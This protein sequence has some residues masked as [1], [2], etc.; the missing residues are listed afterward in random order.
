MKA[1][2]IDEL[3]GMTEVQWEALPVF[4]KVS[5]WIESAKQ[6]PEPNKPVLGFVNDPDYKFQPI[7]RVMWMPKHFEEASFEADF[8]D[9]DEATDC[10]Y[11]PEGWYETNFYEETHWQ[12]DG[13]VLFWRPLPKPPVI[14]SV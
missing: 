6:K 12:V 10:Y 9:Y 14:E 8:T 7:L 5:P 2:D 3:L 4:E 11:W 13:E 1:E